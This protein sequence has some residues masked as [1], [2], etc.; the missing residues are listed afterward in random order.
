[1][2]KRLWRKHR[3]RQNSQTVN[4]LIFTTDTWQTYFIFKIAMQFHGNAFSLQEKQQHL[5]YFLYQIVSS[6][7][8]NVLKW[9]HSKHIAALKLLLLKTNKNYAQ[10]RVS[11][12][13]KFIEVKISQS[14]LNKKQL[15]R[16]E[17]HDVFFL[18]FFLF[19]F[20]D[21][22]VKFRMIVRRD[23]AQTS[24]HTIYTSRRTDEI[25]KKKLLSEERVSSV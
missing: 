16:H 20:F 5:F 2:S 9:N 24:I 19:S 1:M 6:N 11:I 22:S 17:L 15:L 12:A 3:R 21:C 14:N 18:F 4:V 13:F 7:V 8:R 23:E 10:S 25:K